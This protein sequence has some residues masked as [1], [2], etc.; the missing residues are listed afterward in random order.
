MGMSDGGFW[1]IDNT[2]FPKKSSHSVEVVRQ[3]CGVLDK[4]D[5]KQGMGFGH[6]EGRGWRGF[7]HHASVSIA[8]YGFLMAR[9]LKAGGISGGKRNFIERKV[10]AVS[11]D[12][13]PRGSPARAVPRTGFDHLVTPALERSARQRAGFLPTLQLDQPTTMFMTK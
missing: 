4:Q 7:H 2:G 1:I 9:R 3:Y 13:V 10:P 12:Y 11:K 8:A 6:Y 5:L